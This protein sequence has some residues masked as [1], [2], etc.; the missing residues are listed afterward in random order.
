MTFDCVLPLFSENGVEDSEESV[1]ISV[2]L[3]LEEN[4]REVLNRVHLFQET[5]GQVT[6]VWR[7]N[8]RPAVLRHLFSEKII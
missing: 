5:V 3:G 6:E 4:A 2:T 8:G 1:E 7:V